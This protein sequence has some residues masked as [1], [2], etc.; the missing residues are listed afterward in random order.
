MDFALL[1]S[2]SSVYRDFTVT[3]L[4]KKKIIARR[5]KF[6]GYIHKHNI[7]YFWPHFEKQ[8]GLHKHFSNFQQGVLLAH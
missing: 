8:D 7:L 2:R 4:T 5:V 6:A 3:A 1:C